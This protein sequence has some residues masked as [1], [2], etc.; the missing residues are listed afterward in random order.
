MFSG[1]SSRDFAKP[2]WENFPP[3]QWRIVL[4]V[5]IRNL[6]TFLEHNEVLM[7]S[8]ETSTLHLSLIKAWLLV[9]VAGKQAKSLMCC[10]RAALSSPA[11][12][13]QGIT[14][15][16]CLPWAGQGAS[17]QLL[18]LLSWLQNVHKHT[19]VSLRHLHLK[20]KRKMQG[21][22]KTISLMAGHKQLSSGKSNHSHPCTEPGVRV[23][24]G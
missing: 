14:S 3:A 13:V 20:S 2:L 11:E 5:Q 23:S 1:S 19:W 7:A 15:C 16:S 12:R 22:E 9:R 17:S 6:A 24:P 4:V 8:A 10:A 21:L 18:P